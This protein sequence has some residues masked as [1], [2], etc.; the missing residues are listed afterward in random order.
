MNERSSLNHSPDSRVL[1]I[2]ELIARMRNA[3]AACSVYGATHS[4]ITNVISTNAAPM[5]TSMRPAC[6][7]VSPAARITVN[8]ELLARC[9]ST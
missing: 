5:R 4:P 3:C 6:P 9:A 1:P 2:S 7:G 8:S